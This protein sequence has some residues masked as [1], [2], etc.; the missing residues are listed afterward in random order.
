MPTRRPP[1][2]PSDFPEP[3]LRFIELFDRQEFWESHE[4]LEDAWRRTRSGFYHGLI[5]YASAFVH[6]QRSNA[7]GVVAQLRK[8]EKA[9]RPYEPS[10]LGVDIEGI[11]TAAVELRKMVEAAE[12]ASKG[13]ANEVSFPVI[14][15]ETRHI[16]GT[17]EELT[18]I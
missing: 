13:W 11:L 10:Y 9:L 5:L 7:R 8:M 18:S 17:E 6:V 16:R 4:V 1:P 12:E 2:P 14:Q 15:L 3:L